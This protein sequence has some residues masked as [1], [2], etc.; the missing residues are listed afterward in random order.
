MSVKYNLLYESNY[1]DTSAELYHKKKLFG[2]KLIRYYVLQNLMLVKN[3]LLPYKQC[4][5]QGNNDT[6]VFNHP[7]P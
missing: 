2:C 7:T 3:A 6:S 1:A 5:M 4:L